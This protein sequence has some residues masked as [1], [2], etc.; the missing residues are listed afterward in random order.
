VPN[1]DAGIA[2]R[3]S[4]TMAAVVDHRVPDADVPAIMQ[5][6]TRRLFAWGKV[7]YDDVYG[8]SWET[9]FCTNYT[10]FTGTDGQIKVGGYYYRRHNNAT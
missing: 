4:F 7:K 3:Q 1:S 9:N 10:F 6:S 2:P 8:G 5:G